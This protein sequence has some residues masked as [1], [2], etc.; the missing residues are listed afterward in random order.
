MRIDQRRLCT[1]LIALLGAYVLAGGLLSFLGWLLRRAA[2]GGL[3]RERHRNPAER[4]VLRNVGGRGMARSG[5][6]QRGLGNGRSC[7]FV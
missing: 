4:N 6:L 3:G 5:V 2:P 7:A 1:Y